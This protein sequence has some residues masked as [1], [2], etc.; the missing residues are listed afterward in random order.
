MTRQLILS[1]TTSSSSPISPRSRW[2]L[3]ELQSTKLVSDYH[4]YLLKS[5]RISMCGL[6][7]RNVKYVAQAM[8]DVITKYPSGEPQ[9]TLKL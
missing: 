5:G 7:E 6:N 4:I 1:L 3:A 9:V 2:P 8:N